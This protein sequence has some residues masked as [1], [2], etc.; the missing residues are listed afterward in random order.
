MSEETH[1]HETKSAQRNAIQE[2]YVFCTMCVS[3]TCDDMIGRQK[4]VGS[5]HFQ[6]SLSLSLSLPLPVSFAFFLSLSPSLACARSLYLFLFLR[7]SSRGRQGR[8]SPRERKR[9]F[10]T[11]IYHTQSL[12][13]MQHRNEFTRVAIL[14]KWIVSFSLTH[15][16]F[17][18]RLLSSVL[19]LPHTLSPTHRNWFTRLA[20]VTTMELRW[21][22][23]F[24]MLSLSLSLSPSLTVLPTH[25]NELTR[26]ASVTTM[27]RKWI[28]SPNIAEFFCFLTSPAYAYPWYPNIGVYVCG[29]ACACA[30]ACASACA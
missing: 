16:L 21:I 14:M 25:R 13:H 17:L 23:F 24:H 20:S 22:V 12:R 10:S 27:E 29:C 11:Y 6:V 4:F 28:V 19:S 15:A 18:S 3:V 5:T 9:S 2:T 30:C 26:L 7:T 8:A 1:A